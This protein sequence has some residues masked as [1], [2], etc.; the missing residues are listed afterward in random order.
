MENINVNEV[1]RENLRQ[2]NSS[3]SSIRQC[4]VAYET[5][6]ENLICFMKGKSYE[7]TEEAFDRLLEIQTI[8]SEVSFKHGIALGKKL[9]DLVREFDRLEEPYIRRYWYSHFA[10][11]ANWPN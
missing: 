10:N 5:S 4:L 9:D 11:G 1:L 6:A 8:L 2:Y 7:E 3:L